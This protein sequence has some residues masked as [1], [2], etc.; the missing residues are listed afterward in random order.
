MNSL[1]NAMNVE[2]IKAPILPARDKNAHKG[3][4]GT[5]LIMCGSYGMAGAAVLAITACLRS[6]VGIAK[7]V[8][9][10]KI[11]DIVARQVPEAVFTPVST[12]PC[13]T[14]SSV[15]TGKIT[16]LLP[17]ADAVLYGCGIGQSDD[18]TEVLK[19]VIKNAKSPIIIDADGINLLSRN[20]NIIKQ[21]TVPVVLTP[22]PG[23]MSRLCGKGIA[24]IEGSRVN[25]AVEFS[26]E[27][28][29]YTVLKGSETVVAAPDGRVFINKTGNP[30]MATGGSGDALAGILAAFL[31]RER[32]IL[33][34]VM[35]AV[36]IH[37]AAGDMAAEKMSQT[38]LLPR[39]LIEQ[40]PLLFKTL[41]G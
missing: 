18:N 31:A 33:R 23:E 24:E 12:S 17:S 27:Y 34:A 37:G 13:G 41:E 4:F 36:Y 40:L 28:G 35:S 10:D 5:A 20:I 21:I 7:A 39:D 22:H 25:T 19:A 14:F 11:Y 1:Y 2:V 16:E 3:T 8:L 26:R 30:G 6:G 9:P 29:V 15:D 38:S 32:D